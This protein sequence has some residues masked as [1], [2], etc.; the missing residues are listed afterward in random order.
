MTK[1]IRA[2]VVALVLVG[3]AT[4]LRSLLGPQLGS[5]SPFMLYIAAVLVGSVL[6]GA[7]SGLTIAALGGI[8]GLIAFLSPH[9]AVSA[10]DVISLVVFWFVSVVVLMA[11]C[12]LRKAATRRAFPYVSWDQT[13]G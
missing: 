4:F 6:A 2:V 8:I 9:D 1:H 10:A 12:R 7:L 3:A 13:T 11:G 5:D